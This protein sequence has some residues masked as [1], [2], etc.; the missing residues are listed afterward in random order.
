MNHQRYLLI[1]LLVGLFVPAL[2]AAFSIASHHVFE[3]WVVTLAIPG[4]LPF[5]SNDPEQEMSWLSTIAAFA[6]NAGIFGCV[7]LTIGVLRN[8][9]GKSGNNEDGHLPP[10]R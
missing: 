9:G 2:L 4:F 5:A 7:G 10:L 6:L 3:S 8:L 1:G